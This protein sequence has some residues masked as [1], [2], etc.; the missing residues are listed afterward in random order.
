MNTYLNFTYKELVASYQYDQ[1]KGIILSVKTGKQIGSDNG[2][3]LVISR[4]K[5]DKTVN[6]SSGLLAYFLLHKV[7]TSGKKIRYVD[8]NYRNLRPDNLVLC[9]KEFVMNSTPDTRAE[10]IKTEVKGVIYNPNS[11]HYVAQRGSKQAIYRTFDKNEAIMI[12]KEWELNKTIHKWDKTFN[13]AEYG[14]F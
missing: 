13:Y 10:I 1:I 5:G 9:N 14:V 2:S 4:R 6:L 8:G 12:R 11:G 3:G 7:D